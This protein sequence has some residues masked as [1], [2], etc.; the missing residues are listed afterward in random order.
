L[1]L[2]LHLSTGNLKELK[3]KFRRKYLK[4][5]KNNLNQVLVSI[6]LPV[7]NG[8]KFLAHSIKSCLT[9]TYTN[10]ELII[11][12]DCSND[13]SLQIAEY[14]AQK[15]G[16]IKV[17][18]NESNLKLPASLNIGHH[19]AK[20][21]YFTWT[22][23]DNYYEPNAIEIMLQEIS[24]N[25]ADIVHGDF[26]I[27]ELNG[28]SRFN[29]A[30]C[31]N[32]SLLLG[33]NIGSCFLYKREVFIRNGG[34]DEA[35]HTIED[36]DFWLQAQVHSKFRHIPLILYNYRIHEGSLT[37]QLKSKNSLMQVLFQKKLETCYWKFFKT[38][39]LENK[40][41]S[42]LFKNFHLN[43][44]INVYDFLKNYNVFKKDFG[45][46]FKYLDKKIL[47]KEID[48][49][50]R[51]Y[52]FDFTENQNFSTLFLLLK[53]RPFIFFEY[54]TKKSLKIILRCLT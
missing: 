49:K 33:N 9:Q 51:A 32:L 52:I 17:I 50:L 1:H 45:P 54:N 10:F 48:L 35:L 16:R 13:T 8:E 15:D 23:D 22:S 3:S 7:Y 26:N 11:V 47:L 21:D 24:N 31:K 2:K 27:I 30:M 34:Y 25:N 41:Y 38:Y 19:H 20:G 44:K 40:G 28:N 37:S 39:N 5:R 53:N 18:S 14:F 46:I 43:Q 4:V 42:G 36:Y 12:N 6:V 29:N